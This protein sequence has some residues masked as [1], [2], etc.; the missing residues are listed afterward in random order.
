MKLRSTLYVFTYLLAIVLANLS[1]S[2][3]GPRVAI[4]NAFLFIGLDLTARDRLHDA[5]QGRKLFLKMA[6]LIGSGSLLSYALNH[7][8]GPV[9]VASFAA[10]ACAATVDTLVY[11]RLHH[12]PRWA[13]INGS[14]IPSAAVDSVV[15]PALAFGFP[16]LWPIMIGQFFAKVFGGFVWSLILSLSPLSSVRPEPEPAAERR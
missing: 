15:F 8:A 1:V 9:A 7:D 12:K 5:W 13:R 2:M 16:L 4:A 14:N 10:F 6:A 11:Q 3:L